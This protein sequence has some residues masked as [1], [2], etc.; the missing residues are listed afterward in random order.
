MA[1]KYSSNYEQT[2]PLSDVCAQ[3]HLTANVG[4]QFVVPGVDT[5]KYSVLFSY[6]STSNVF[7]CN[8]AAPVIP[9]ANTVG[10]QQYNE[11]RPGEDSVTKRYVKGGDVLHFITPD[12]TAYVGIR[13]MQLP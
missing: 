13:L 6:I 7:V 9:A 8:N 5:I 11:F 1:I 2:I 10:V 4:Q 3:I 12:A